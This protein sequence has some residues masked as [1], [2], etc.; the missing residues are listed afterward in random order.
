MIKI[1]LVEDDLSLSKSVYDFLKS[2]A[3]VKQVFDG[4]EGLYEA[5]M[6]I[7]DLILL[8]LMLPEKKGFEV[9]KE[10]RDQNIDTPVLIMTAKESLDDKMHGFDVGADDYL[11]KPFYLDELKARIQALLKR[12]GKLEDANGLSYG[13]VRLN[14]TNKSAFVNDTPVEL[15]GKEF[16]LVVYL[17]QNQNVILPK[18][19]IFDRLWGFDSDTTV[20]VVEVYM[21]KIRKKLKD[22]DFAQNLATLRN[23]GYI[24]R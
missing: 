17:M 20:T 3:E 11:T 22:T 24:L 9:L 7:Y 19:Q 2:F 1:L 10:L 12:T 18:E 5:E 15:I 14:L 4:E 13:N 23:V 16:D 8:D 6:G 21:S